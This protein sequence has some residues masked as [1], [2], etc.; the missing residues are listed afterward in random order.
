MIPDKHAEERPTMD[1]EGDGGGGQKLRDFFAS[2]SALRDK[3][4][5]V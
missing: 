2:T 5:V 4:A 3:S 1:L